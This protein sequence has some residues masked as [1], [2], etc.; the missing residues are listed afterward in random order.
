MTLMTTVASRKRTLVSPV[1]IPP[2]EFI[3]YSSILNDST[4]TISIPSGTANGDMMFLVIGKVATATT[5]CAGWT[6]VYGSN[7][8][9]VQVYYKVA[10][11]EGASVTFTRS[12]AQNSPR[13]VLVT[14][15]GASAYSFATNA[16]VTTDVNNSLVG[17]FYWTKVDS[18][19]PYFSTMSNP[20]LAD[21]TKEVD[22][23]S[24][25]GDG[26]GWALGSGVKSTSGAVQKNTSTP[27][28][29][30]LEFRLILEPKS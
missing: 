12:S 23:S 26:G 30:Y 17:T 24:T 1:V 22:V 2:P 28:S 7:A 16:S 21:F 20:D 9:L 10:N 14:Y 25:T 29:A 6:P 27:A 3:N 4:T 18:A 5:S 19:S 13:T 8:G 15:R 11:N